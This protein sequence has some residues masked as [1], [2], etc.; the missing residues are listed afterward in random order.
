MCVYNLFNSI[1][2]THRGNR[3]TIHMY[4]CFLLRP[5]LLYHKSLKYL[6]LFRFISFHLTIALIMMIVIVVLKMFC[7]V[8]VSLKTSVALD[9]TVTMVISVDTGYRKMTIVL[10]LKLQ[11]T[12]YQW[13]LLQY[14]VI[15]NAWFYC[16][17]IDTT[18]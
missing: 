18:L 15:Y 5:Q 14:I 3:N 1:P 17:N 16:F 13:T 8:G 9:L 2:S 7:V 11:W 12:V 4:H 6:S 10:T